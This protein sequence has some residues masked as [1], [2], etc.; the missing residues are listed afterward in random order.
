[1]IIKLYDWVPDLTDFQMDQ[2][3]KSA[4]RALELGGDYLHG[5]R[6]ALISIGFELVK[7]E[8]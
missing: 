2:L 8:D 3:E 4:K 5:F 1:M 6:I 7:K